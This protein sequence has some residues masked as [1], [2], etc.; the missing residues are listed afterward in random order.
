MTFDIRILSWAQPLIF[1][2]R[3][4]FPPRGKSIATTFFGL[5]NLGYF[6]TPFCGYRGQPFQNG[7]LYRLVRT[8]LYGSDHSQ[9]F[10]TELFAIDGSF[11][12]ALR[13]HT[14]THNFFKYI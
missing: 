9:V 4:R 1:I 6:I 14:I 11:T 2:L 5:I 3:L 10:I 13:G 7:G 12:V 8:C